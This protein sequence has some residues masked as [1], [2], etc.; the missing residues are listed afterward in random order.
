MLA[1]Q[2]VLVA[3]AAALLFFFRLS[4]PFLDFDSSTATP[5]ASTSLVFETITTTL[6]QN[7]PVSTQ[8]TVQPAIMSA[9][10]QT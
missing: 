1:V 5:T 3:A 10:E 2:V 7:I 6:T 8:E 4:P 9:S